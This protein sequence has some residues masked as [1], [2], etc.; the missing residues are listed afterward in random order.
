MFSPLQKR[1]HDTHIAQNIGHMFGTYDL[2]NT[3]HAGVLSEVPDRLRSDRPR[4][5]KKPLMEQDAPGI[6]SSPKRLA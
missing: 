4:K 2:F 1:Q 5:R 3:V 6:P